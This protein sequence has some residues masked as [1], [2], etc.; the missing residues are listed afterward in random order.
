MLSLLQLY[1]ESHMQRAFVRG[2]NTVG[3]RSG[4]MNDQPA[5]LAV[6]RVQD[7]VGELSIN[8]D[9]FF[10]LPTTQTMHLEEQVS[11][12]API[13]GNGHKTRF[14]AMGM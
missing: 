2:M 14:I 12:G 7:K 3:I 13:S 1:H 6:D 9:P 11:S 4:T 8:L 5:S 10:R